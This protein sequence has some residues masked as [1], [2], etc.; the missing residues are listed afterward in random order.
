MPFTLTMPKL[1]PTMESGMI[2]KWHKKI[3]DQVQPGDLLIEVATDKAT[4]EFNAIDG[5]FLRQILIPENKEA[6]VNQPIAIFTERS[7]ESI[8]GYKPE[9]EGGEEKVPVQATPQQKPQPAPKPQPVQQPAVPQPV[10]ETRILASP[11]AKKMAKDR[12]LDLGSVTGTGPGG[13]IMARDLEKA[14]PVCQK[15]AP[16]IAAGTFSQKAAPTI[17]AGTFETENLTPMR[18]IIAQRLQEAKSTIPHFYVSQTI[19]A[20][21]LIDI[22]EQLRNF[23]LKVTI[24]DLVLRACALTLRQHPKVNSGFDVANQTIM[25]FKT[26]DIA[27]AVSVD[28]GLITPIVRHADF[29]NVSDLSTEVRQLAKRAKEGKLEPQEYQG[30]S[31]TLS[32]LGMF[33]V[34]NFA[35]IINPPQAAILAVSGIQDQPVVRHGAVVPGKVMNLTLSVDHRVVDGVVAA[36]FIKTLQKYLENPALLLV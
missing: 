4:V 35:A 26:I 1:S 23:E 3:G 5:G 25:R 20:E 28:A 11:L 24:N 32:N 30:G 27:V 18:R 13:R 6:I 36:E 15:A 21:A 7:E 8:E 29:K 14:Q 22:R 10:E 17:A 19:Q 9:G 34:T 12:G 33:G 2:A 16:T 31:F